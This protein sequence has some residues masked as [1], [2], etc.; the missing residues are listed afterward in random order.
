MPEALDLCR[1][2][3][4]EAAS[5]AWASFVL[6]PLAALEAMA[7]H[8]DGARAH[9]DEARLQRRE[10]PAAGSI[11]S[12][13]SAFAAEV[14]LLADNP[15]GAEEILLEACETLR[16]AGDREWLATNTA[17][18]GEARYRDGRFEAALDAADEALSLAPPGHLTSCAVALRVRA[19]ALAR[20]GSE[21]AT[22]AALDAI[23]RLADAEVL[24]DR[25]E[26]HAY[27]AEVF[28]LAGEPAEADRHR[29]RALELFER[30]GNVVSAVRVREAI[31]AVE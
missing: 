2:L 26:A 11:A 9:L 24:N 16:R 5:P 30:K 22:V 12:N 15:A 19:A 1:F 29:R 13:W 23:T 8:F 31:V 3:L 27:A 28:A 25:A 7:E 10:F 14:E 6:P 4:A 18:L 20:T 17:S 21:E